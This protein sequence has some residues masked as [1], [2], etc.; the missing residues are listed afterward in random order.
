M[1]DTGQVVSSIGS[2]E[3]L[4]YS[5]RIQAMRSTVITP[6]MIAQANENS[7]TDEEGL[8]F[9]EEGDGEEGGAVAET[10]AEVV[11]DPE[12][13]QDVDGGRKL[14]FRREDGTFAPIPPEK[15]EWMVKDPTTGEERVYSKSIPEVQRMALDGIS[16]TRLGNE[17]HQTKARAAEI[18]QSHQN[19]ITLARQLE[20]ERDAQI[21]LNREM[22]A[23]ESGQA[24]ASRRE[25]FMQANSPERRLHLL[26]QRIQEREQQIQQDTTFRQA[27]EQATRALNEARPLVTQAMDGLDDVEQ[28]AVL[29]RLTTAT[30]H[31]TRNGKIPTENHGAYMEYLRG[32]LQEVA[33]SIRSRKAA[34]GQ[35]QERTTQSQKIAQAAINEEARRAKSYG[36]QSG[37]A[38]KDPKIEGS[39]NDRIRAL[40]KK[41]YYSLIVNEA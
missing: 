9:E 37:E 21:K 23:D 6:D 26:E 40:K 5:E 36:A 33:N 35:A 34:Q 20:A 13:W 14:R 28:D 11:G 39:M 4:T 8:D 22:L 29:G 25:Q 3:P 15:I 32:P 16:A 31:L 30:L 1:A 41:D 7:D 10:K 24:W 17:L 27:T 2:S 18:E 38:K 19:I 12:G